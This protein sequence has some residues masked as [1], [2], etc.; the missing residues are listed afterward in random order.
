VDVDGVGAVVEAVPPEETMY[1][2]SEAPELAVAV[3]GVANE[4]WQYEIG[5]TTVGAE[6]E[7]LTET[8]TELLFDVQPLMVTVT[9]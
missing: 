9:A 8:T 5:V 3:S 1:H 6:R 4:F 2:L 7:E